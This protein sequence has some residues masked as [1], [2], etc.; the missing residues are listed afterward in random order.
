[1]SAPPV[2]ADEDAWV[3]SVMRSSG[4]LLVE[5]RAVRHTAGASVVVRSHGYLAE[6]AI[7]GEQRSPLG[8]TAAHQLGPR[9]L[10][11]ISPFSQRTHIQDLLTGLEA[12]KQR[13]Q[14]CPRIGGFQVIERVH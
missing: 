4:N 1:M 3:E 12:S 2:T 14:R 8:G 6:A 10:P 9:S 13:G 11:V 7:T 5:H